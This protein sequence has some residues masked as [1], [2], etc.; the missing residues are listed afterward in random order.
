MVARRNPNEARRAS[1]TLVELLVV[2][3]VL[4]V[5]V[6]IVVFAVGSISD[7]GEDA[8]AKVDVRALEVAE[9]H[10]FGRSLEFSGSPVYVSES[11]L[12]AERRLRGVSSTHDICLRSDAK[13]Y[14]VDVAGSDCSIVP[15]G[16]T[17]VFS[18]AP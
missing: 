4:G 3:T 8:A 12:V 15:S 7:R 1:F 16:Q 9:E 5:L 6:S 10:A 17:G 18:P 13:D 11:Q 14:F 2:V